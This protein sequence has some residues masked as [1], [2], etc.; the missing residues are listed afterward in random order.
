M[1]LL[2]LVPYTPTPIRTRPYNLVRSLAR[3][4][5]AVTLAT[6]WESPGEQQALAGLAGEGLEVIAARLGRP[7]AAANLLGAVF[8]RRPLQ[9]DFCWQ[10]GLARALR[11]RLAPGA[12][13]YDGVLVEHLRGARYALLLKSLL[14]QAS[15]DGAASSPQAL[16]PSPSRA[17]VIWD[18][19]DC[20]SYLFEQAARHSR[21]RFGRLMTQ[22]ELGRTRRYEAFLAGQFPRV[23][24]T[25][26]ADQEALERLAREY[27]PPG[28][29]AKPEVFVLPNG[30][31]LDFFM[32]HLGER[33]GN[34]VVLTGKM[35]YH[36]NVTAALYLVE[37]VMPRVW[38]ARPDARVEIVGQA[39]PPEVRALA[40]RY[41]GR[42]VVTG[43]VP[44][45]RPHLWSAAVAA[46]PIVYGAGTQNK[47]LEAMACAAPVVATPQA[48]S[49][50]QARAGEDVLV[51]ETAA[52]LAEQIL[53]LLADEA[54]R[55]R[56]GEAGRRYVTQHHNWGA[57]AALL[58]EHF[59]G[60][61]GR[62]A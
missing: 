28:P 46:A 59:R 53:G 22:F 10:P 9:A 45:V 17:P 25:S 16:T 23:L 30:V 14:A 39:P 57:A 48:V 3:R 13:P 20:I 27:P 12:P 54:L 55:R 51:G 47:V 31:D 5:H 8:T 6:L 41:P 7:R 33:S 61:A 52:V 26:A 4:G 1:R 50:L 60:L 56:L 38:A 18:S 15:F 19:V 43:R 34:T 37:E 24:V 32:P 21:R 49:A 36:A 40:E 2:Y 11:A 44:D 29:K 42:V 35:S 58:E 62:I